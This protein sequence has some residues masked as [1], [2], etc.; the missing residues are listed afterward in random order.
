MGIHRLSYLKGYTE[1]SGV[2]MTILLANAWVLLFRPDTYNTP[3]AVI[4]DL[5]AAVPAI[6]WLTYKNKKQ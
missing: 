6:I 1:G 4:A 5:F 2:A 3:A